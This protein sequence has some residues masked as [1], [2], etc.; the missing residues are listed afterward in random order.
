[1]PVPVSYLR[2]PAISLRGISGAVS[3]EVPPVRFVVR[4][5]TLERAGRGLIQAR[6]SREQWLIRRKGRWRRV[7]VVCCHL[8]HLQD[9]LTH[10]SIAERIEC[11][12][13]PRCPS[14]QFWRLPSPFPYLLPAMSFSRA[15]K[16]R[17]QLR[18]Q[19]VV[20]FVCCQTAH[21]KRA[22]SERD[23]RAGM[24]KTTA[25]ASHLGPEALLLRGFGQ[26]VRN[27]VRRPW[28]MADDLFDLCRLRADALAIDFAGLQLLRKAQARAFTCRQFSREVTGTRTLLCRSASTA[29]TALGLEEIR[30]DL[31]HIADACLVLELHQVDSSCA[32]WSDCF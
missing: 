32:R 15:R 6:P 7:D 17:F 23:T 10:P 5:Q 20:L 16:S 1:M 19:R 30:H 14:S 22:R 11:R 26:H 8:V 29:K 31:G 4:V 24:K 28:V 27:L 21:N 18:Q 9:V 25:S 2:C 3:G 12:L 13:S